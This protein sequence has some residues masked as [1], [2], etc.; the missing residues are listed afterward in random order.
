MAGR[1][2]TGRPPGRPPKRGPGRPKKEAPAPP[3]NVTSL[4]LV[5]LPKEDVPSM[6]TKPA[7]IED[8]APTPKQALFHATAISCLAE[9]KPHPAQ[10]MLRHFEMHGEGVT[11][12]EFAR[13]KKD[14]K[15]TRWFYADLAYKVDE[16]D[17]QIAEALFHQQLLQKVAAG[18]KDAMVLFAN[19]HG[20][21][22][23]P[24]GDDKGETTV[25]DLLRE[26]VSAPTVPVPET[27]WSA[28]KK[29]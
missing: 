23:R 6:R 5:S 16:D 15:F 4:R 18:D 28:A 3:S 8:F 14:K 22:R 24:R 27:A 21:R 29:S 10:W 7:D 13:W 2:P 9:G 11:G 26:F 20:L 19:V 17:Q 1:K 12:D 25:E